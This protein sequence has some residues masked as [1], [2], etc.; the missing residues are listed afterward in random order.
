MFCVALIVREFLSA[1]ATYFLI[2][3]SFRRY[4]TSFRESFHW[5]TREVR[6]GVSDVARNVR[7]TMRVTVDME[8]FRN[9]ALRCAL[10]FLRRTHCSFVRFVI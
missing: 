8:N 7:I 4:G 2:Y 3:L 10:C 1:D 6:E 9:D 5:V